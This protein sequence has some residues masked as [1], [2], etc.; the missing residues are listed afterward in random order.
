MSHRRLFTLIGLGI[1]CFVFV[2]LIWTMTPSS[3]TAQCGS[4]PPPDSNCYTCHVQENPVEGNGEWHG[5]HG[6]KDYCAECH[7][8]NCT[9][10]DKDLAHQGVIFNPLTDIY[11]N[12]HSCHPDNYQDLANTFATELGITPSSTATPT[13]VPTQKFI[14][15]SLIVLPS[16]TPNTPAAFPMPIALVAFIVAILILVGII[17][18]ILHLIIR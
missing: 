5:I 13:S 16:P 1:L 8:G 6:Q 15:N 4:N 17:M 9:A 10:M 2:G 18:H 11:T 3:V 7:G 12:C 14:A